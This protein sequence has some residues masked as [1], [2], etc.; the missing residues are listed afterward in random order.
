LIPRDQPNRRQQSTAPTGTTR[1]AD[2][3]VPGIEANATQE[4]SA[5][6]HAGGNQRAREMSG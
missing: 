6:Q 3:W 4:K 5:R 1:D 2:A